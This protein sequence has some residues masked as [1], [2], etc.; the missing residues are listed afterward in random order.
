MLTPALVDYDEWLYEDVKSPLDQQAAVMDLISQQSIR[1]KSQPVVH[2]YIGFDPLRE[3]AHRA[4]KSSVSSL[5]TARS[6]L[7]NHGFFGVKLY[8]PMGF[9]P[10]GN[11]GPYPKRTITSLGF[12]PSKRLDQA[13]LDLYSLCVEL[14]API[15]A[16]GYASNGSGPQYELRGD[17]A[18]WIPV[19]ERFRSL[20]VCIAHFGRFDTHSAGWEKRPL[21]EGSWEWRLGHFIKE[22]PRR[23][24][25]A[26]ISYFSEALNAK[27][28]QRQI[29]ARDFKLW[30]SSFDPEL[31]H[32]IFG[33]DWIMLGKEAGYDHYVG[34]VNSFLRTDCGFSDVTCDKIFRRNAMRFLPLEKSSKGRARMLSYY[35]KNRLD[36]SRLPAANTKL[37]AGVFG[38]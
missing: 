30:A 34:S 33:S 6:A 11:S 27:P 3:V 15:L 26:D 32:L 18:Y 13:L 38:R 35:R 24:V 36:A 19:F 17:S 31:D 5:E 10:S 1:A 29:L 28:E 4:G 2:G 21:P 9:R 7:V 25:F 20:R 22:N 16:H 12:D 37:F 23:P 14:D 8:P